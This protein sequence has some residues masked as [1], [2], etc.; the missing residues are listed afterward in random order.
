MGKL[1]LNYKQ[2]TG[3]DWFV[4]SRFLYS[5]NKIDQYKEIKYKDKTK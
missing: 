3:R 2:F 5:Q 4:Y 1:S